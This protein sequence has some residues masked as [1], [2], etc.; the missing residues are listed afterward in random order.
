MGFVHFLG[1][2]IVEKQSPIV[3][4]KSGRRFNMLRLRLRASNASRYV[5]SGLSLSDGRLFL[6]FFRLND[7][8]ANFTI[9]DVIIALAD[10]AGWKCALR[11]AS[12]CL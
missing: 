2:T 8:P 4:L 6:G 11:D 12:L 10:R 9:G 3:A 1:D 5:P 7:S